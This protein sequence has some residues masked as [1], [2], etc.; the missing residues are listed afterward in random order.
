LEGSERGGQLLQRCALRGH[1]RLDLRQARRRVLGSL[2]RS[3][4]RLHLLHVQV[5]QRKAQRGGNVGPV[6]L[7]R[8]QVRREDGRAGRRRRWHCAVSARQLAWLAE[9][10]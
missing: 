5:V 4:L 2:R 8:Q 9:V 10:E 3:R 7:A 6:I 1:A